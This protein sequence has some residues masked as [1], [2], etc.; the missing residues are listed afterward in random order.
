[1]NLVKI[2]L[3]VFTSVTFAKAPKINLASGLFYKV[4][5]NC[6][7][8]HVEESD[9]E[10]SNIIYLHSK[11]SAE[12]IMILGMNTTTAAFPQIVRNANNLYL[13]K[14]RCSKKFHFEST[15]KNQQGKLFGP[16]VARNVE[17]SPLIFSDNLNGIDGT[18]IIFLNEIN[19]I[20][21]QSNSNRD[22]SKDLVLYLFPKKNFKFK[23]QSEY[24][25]KFKINK[26]V[27]YFNLPIL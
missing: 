6:F 3:I 18:A 14:D 7:P 22:R 1:M 5:T 21:F 27:F 16:Y 13:S 23:N 19:F 2:L 11:Q 20:D 24:I 9:S 12:V 10:I 15:L 4:L 25:Y 26:E 8:F 17:Q